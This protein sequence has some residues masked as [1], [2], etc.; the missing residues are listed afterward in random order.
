[1]EGGE[2]F[3]VEVL[4]HWVLTAEG[5]HGT[6]FLPLLACF[7]A[8]TLSSF[9]LPHAPATMYYFTTDPKQWSQPLIMG[10]NLQ[11]REPE[12]NFHKLSCLAYFL[13]VMEY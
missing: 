10:Y 9:A 3:E 1:M 8:D 11:D 7:V 13:T 6:G 2:I 4:G 5:G 12:Q